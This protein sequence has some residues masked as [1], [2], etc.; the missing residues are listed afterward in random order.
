MDFQVI[1]CAN[2]CGNYILITWV[3]F[4]EI[5]WFIVVSWQENSEWS[6]YKFGSYIFYCRSKWYGSMSPC[7]AVQRIGADKLVMCSKH[8]IRTSLVKEKSQNL[9]KS[10]HLEKGWIDLNPPD[11]RS[12][13][14]D[15]VVDHNF[16]WS[17]GHVGE[18]Y[19]VTISHSVLL[20]FN[21]TTCFG[22]FWVH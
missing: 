21:F 16:T 10:T 20:I 3:T 5:Y 1:F 15:L 19:L 17:S 14:N 11:V 9:R 13:G 6:V 22:L 18:R 7:N 4:S 8:L 12:L 2:E